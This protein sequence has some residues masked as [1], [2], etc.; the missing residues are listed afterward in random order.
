MRIG[1][2]SA[3]SQS[4][5][6]LE[7]GGCQLV[8]TGVVVHIRQFAVGRS[9]AGVQLNGLAQALPGGV[10]VARTH[11]QLPFFVVSLR[12][13]GVG[14]NGA[15]EAGHGLAAALVRVQEYVATS[16]HQGRVVLLVRRLGRSQ[17][18]L[19]L[20]H[21]L[22]SRLAVSLR[23]HGQQLAVFVF[24]RLGGGIELNFGWGHLA[25]GQQG[26]TGG[27]LAKR[28]STRGFVEV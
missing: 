1:R 22:R 17:V 16:H 2:W 8:L 28:R 26:P 18:G 5:V 13:A 10:E 27:N 12:V 15:V 24:G 14:G 19:R 11:T 23:N 4:Q 21:V 25:L 6:F 3:L 20:A 7:G 9:V